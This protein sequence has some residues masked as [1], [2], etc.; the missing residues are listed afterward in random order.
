MKKLDPRVV[1]VFFLR[2]ALRSLFFLVFLAIWSFSFVLGNMG[3]YLNFSIADFFL[4]LVVLIIWLALCYIWAKLTYH[5]YGYE[6]T[7]IGFK[8]ESGIITKKYVTIPYDRIQNVDIN[9]GL[10]S[11][12]FGISDVSIQTAGSSAI[13][14]RYGAV[15]I[16]AEGYLPGL[17]KE[18]AEELRDKLIVISHQSKNHGL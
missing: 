3:F 12:F 16:G 6:I 17:S 4:I 18:V 8:K 2:T 14:G 5:F 11:R 10:I 7:E 15:G 1:W 13:V 9:R